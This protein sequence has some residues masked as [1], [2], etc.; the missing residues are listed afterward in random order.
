MD[1][2]YDEQNMARYRRLASPAVAEAER[3]RLLDLLGTEMDKFTELHKAPRR[4]PG[5]S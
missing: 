3:T 5:A 1:R 2:F 4:P